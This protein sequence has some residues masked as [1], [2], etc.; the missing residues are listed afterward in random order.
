VAIWQRKRR[1]RLCRKVE[2]KVQNPV[3]YGGRSGASS[4]KGG[5]SRL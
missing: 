3:E 1:L 5:S 2:K 4:A